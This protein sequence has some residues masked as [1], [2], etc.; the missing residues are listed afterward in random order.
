MGYSAAEA[1]DLLKVQGE[2]CRQEEEG[3]AV[4]TQVGEEEE[5]EEQEQEG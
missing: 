3:R 4:Y 2:L 5:E 1:T